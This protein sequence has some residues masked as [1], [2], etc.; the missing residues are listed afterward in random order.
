MELVRHLRALKARHSSTQT[1]G[2]VDS[3]ALWMAA[4]RLCDTS[5]TWRGSKSQTK[6]PSPKFQ[7]PTDESEAKPSELLDY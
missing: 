6:G 5:S 2:P 3:A 4:P 7:S 1:I